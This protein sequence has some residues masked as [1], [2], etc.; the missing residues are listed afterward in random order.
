LR[1]R[2]RR[3]LGWPSSRRWAL[4]RA[5]PC[6]EALADPRFEIHIDTEGRKVAGVA[7]EIL[8]RTGI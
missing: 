4:A 5:G 7:A 8:A 3:R 2:L 1:R 6:A